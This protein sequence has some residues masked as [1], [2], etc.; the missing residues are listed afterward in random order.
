MRLLPRLACSFSLA[1]VTSASAIAW[2]TPSVS[3]IDIVPGANG[4]SP[5]TPFRHGKRV[6][7][8]AGDATGGRHLYASDGTTTGTVPVVPVPS[9]ATTRMAHVTGGFVFVVG[10]TLYRSDGTPAGT[11]AV[12][13]LP[14]SP[15]SP[16]PPSYGVIGSTGSVAIL[17]RYPDPAN[18]ANSRVVRTDGTVAGTY[19]LSE[20]PGLSPFPEGDRSEGKLSPILYE[21]H[22]HFVTVSN[23]LFRTNG[24]TLEEAPFGTS[25]QNVLS[26]SAMVA[27]GGA[28]WRHAGTATGA[29]RVTATT[30]TEMPS[31]LQPG[32]LGCAGD[33]LV[34]FR[35]D[36]TR[37]FEPWAA[38]PGGNVVSLG[39]LAPG[40]ANSQETAAHPALLPA[41]GGRVVFRACDVSTSQPDSCHA[42]T[43][44]G[45]AAGTTKTA[46][47]APANLREVGRLSDRAYLYADDRAAS[48][49]VTTGTTVT[50]V[51]QSGAPLAGRRSADPAVLDF[52]HAVPIGNRLV[53]R[54]YTE[55][56]G[57]ELWVMHDPDV[58]VVEEPEDA[59]TPPR[60]SGSSTDASTPPPNGDTGREESDARD[61]PTNESGS[62]G[63]SSAGGTSSAAASGFVALLVLSVIGAT[64]RQ[65]SE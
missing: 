40:T 62:G 61:A 3:V 28:L 52:T 4:S 63:C 50:D 47:K 58:A 11:T 5:S 2:A 51:P 18:H 19:N 31:V 10:E 44:D 22:L 65:R 30:A 12:M 13:T 26:N 17:G 9:G 38:D 36:V 29:L 64:R 49:Y 23:R 35:N 43:S 27:C 57:D 15:A 42:W 46:V 48:I 14:R 6:Y 8:T 32:T 45:T 20:E 24:T 53:H 39:D 54:T 1:V 16:N 41:I 33:R 55:G 59:G 25:S 34:F 21:G 60:D 37:G 7:F 56:E